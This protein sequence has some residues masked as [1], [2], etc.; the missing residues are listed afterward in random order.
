VLVAECP[1][2][3]VRNEEHLA[4]SISV[5]NLEQVRPLAALTRTMT[6]A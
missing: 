2:L 6:F 5:M 1:E 3:F 4:A